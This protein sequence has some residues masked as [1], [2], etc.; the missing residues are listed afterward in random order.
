LCFVE[1]KTRTARD[2][3]PAEIAVDS[4]KRIT[5]RRWPPYVRQLLAKPP[6]RSA[7]LLSVYLVPGQEKEFVHSRMLRL[8]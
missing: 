1:V 2:A 6:Q 3:A 5:L 8:E 7:R 4:H